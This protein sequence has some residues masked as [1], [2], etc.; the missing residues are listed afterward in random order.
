MKLHIIINKVSCGKEPPQNSTLS[1]E[2]QCPWLPGLDSTSETLVRAQRAADKSK[3]G[4]GRSSQGTAKR[5]SVRKNCSSLTAARRGRCY[6]PICGL[7]IPGSERLRLA[8]GP[9]VAELW[10]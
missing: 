8:R 2:L 9:P 7:G 4:Q 5:K 6:K 10:N 1:W 3:S